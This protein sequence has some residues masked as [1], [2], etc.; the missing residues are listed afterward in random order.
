MS[1]FFES[2]KDKAVKGEGGAQL[3]ISVLQIRRGN[4]DNIGIIFRIF[5]FKQMLGLLIR[6]V[7]IS[8]NEGSQQC[9][10]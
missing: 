9:L 8:S 1:T 6:T 7:S 4:R 10:C 3:F 5:P 2:G